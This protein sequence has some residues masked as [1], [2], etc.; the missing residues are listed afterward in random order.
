PPLDLLLREEDPYPAVFLCRRHDVLSSVRV[1]LNSQ[2]GY[3]HG[4]R[5]GAFRPPPPLH[6]HIAPVPGGVDLPPVHPEPGEER[7]PAA[8]RGPLERLPDTLR[9]AQGDLA[10]PQRLRG[11]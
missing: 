6:R 8:L 1:R 10:E 11:R 3:D 2:S 4:D 9:G 5:P 7:P